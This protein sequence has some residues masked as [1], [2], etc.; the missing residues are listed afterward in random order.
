MT[1]KGEMEAAHE[2]ADQVSKHLEGWMIGGGEGYW[3][4]LNGPNGA[5]VT[6]CYDASAGGRYRLR[7]IYPSDGGTPGG[8]RYYGVTRFD[9]DPK[10]TIT[11]S[12]KR[13]PPIAARDIARRLL[14]RYLELYEKCRERA[15]ELE[16]ARKRIHKRAEGLA[17]ACGG[18]I[19]EDA[20]GELVVYESFSSSGPGVAIKIHAEEDIDIE[21]RRVPYSLAVRIARLVGKHNERENL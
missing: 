13:G 11:V 5:R 2:W 10:D 18:R 17:E 3:P 8:P 21:L 20:P 16:N 7:G 14:P 4:R 1:T 12:A 9:E 6:I 15:C 19:R